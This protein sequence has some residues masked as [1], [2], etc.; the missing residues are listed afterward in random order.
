MRGVAA[1]LSPFASCYARAED[2]WASPEMIGIAHYIST[3]CSHINSLVRRYLD[4]DPEL[5]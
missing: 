4:Q 2:Q 1:L 3:D 5:I